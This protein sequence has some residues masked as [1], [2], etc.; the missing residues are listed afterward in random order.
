MVDISRMVIEGSIEREKLDFFLYAENL[1][2][3]PNR[4]E[5]I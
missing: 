5:E 4:D 2:Y 1:T 3:D